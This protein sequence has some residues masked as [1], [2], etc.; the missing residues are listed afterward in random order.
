MTPAQW[1]A[2]GWCV[3]CSAAPGEP[4]V[5]VWGKSTTQLVTGGPLE[6]PHPQR[7]VSLMPADAASMLE[8]LVDLSIKEGVTVGPDDTLVLRLDP[9]N[10]LGEDVSAE[11]NQIREFMQSKVPNGARVVIIAAP[12]QL[13]VVRAPG[14]GPD[15]GQ[16]IAA[17]GGM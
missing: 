1:A 14:R 16:H 17:S 15:G 7:S 4:C 13:A 11:L 10:M 5:A 6:T 9:D 12:G 8:D 3:E 2:F